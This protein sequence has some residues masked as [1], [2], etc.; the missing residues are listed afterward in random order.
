MC[1]SVVS[2]EMLKGVHGGELPKEMKRTEPLKDWGSMLLQG[3]GT[4]A[5]VHANHSDGHDQ[6]P[7]CSP[8]LGTNQK[9]E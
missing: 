6:W 2:T 5:Q 3:V 9:Q 1:V 8:A 4:R 7:H